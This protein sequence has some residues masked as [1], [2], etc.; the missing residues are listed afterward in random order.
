MAFRLVNPGWKSAVQKKAEQHAPAV[1]AWFDANP[2]NR[3]V[4]LAE[5][6]EALPG[7]AGDL[8]RAVVN[9]IAVI[10]GAQAEGAED[11]A[12]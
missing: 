1:R 4:T 12:A 3:Y 11:S 8:S 5:L 7:I 10:I 2:E 9:Q 6:R